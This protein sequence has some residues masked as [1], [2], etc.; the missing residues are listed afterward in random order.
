MIY[1][2]KAISVQATEDSIAEL[3]FDL[4]EITSRY[5]ETRHR[6]ETLTLVPT[7]AGPAELPIVE[8]PWSRMSPR[9]AAGLVNVDVDVP[10]EVRSAIAPGFELDEER[11]GA[12]ELVEVVGQRVEGQLLG[13]SGKGRQHEGG[14]QGDETHGARSCLLESSLTLYGKQAGVMR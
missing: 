12:G 14:Q 9:P 3:C 13:R 5:E 8:V 6:V 1:S 7:R 2:G 10:W 11:L 4:Q